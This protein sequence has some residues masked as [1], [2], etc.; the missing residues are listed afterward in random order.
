[1]S[2]PFKNQIVINSRMLAEWVIFSDT[3]IELNSKQRGREG[4]L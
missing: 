3:D 2:V 1:M 4:N